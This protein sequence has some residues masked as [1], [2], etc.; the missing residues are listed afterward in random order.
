MSV[1]AGLRHDLPRLRY[2]QG[3]VRLDCLETAATMA[4]GF[5][6]HSWM[7]PEAE[8]CIDVDKSWITAKRSASR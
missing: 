4:N 1:S 7:Y 5:G 8:G 6:N 3:L 2:R